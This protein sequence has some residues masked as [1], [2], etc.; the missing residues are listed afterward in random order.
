MDVAPEC[1]VDVQVELQT[2][3][4]ALRGKHALLPVVGMDLIAGERSEAHVPVA[5]ARDDLWD[6]GPDRVSVKTVVMRHGRVVAAH[7]QEIDL[8]IVLLE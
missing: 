2:L 6:I 8:R 1:T 3:L 7:D 5:L 4:V